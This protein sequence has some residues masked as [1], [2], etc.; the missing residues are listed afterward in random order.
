MRAGKR[1]NRI[2]GRLKDEN[3]KTREDVKR[4][5]AEDWKTAQN[6]RL[7]EEENEEDIMNMK[8]KFCFQENIIQLV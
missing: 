2:K 5:V 7:K 3:I 8:F 6:V 1:L 4:M